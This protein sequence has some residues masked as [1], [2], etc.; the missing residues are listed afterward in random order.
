MKWVKVT[1]WTKDELLA[2]GPAELFEWTRIVTRYK[3]EED[4]IILLFNGF[5]QLVEMIEDT[6]PEDAVFEIWMPKDPPEN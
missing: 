3:E 2:R 5:D 4:G 1:E 6:V